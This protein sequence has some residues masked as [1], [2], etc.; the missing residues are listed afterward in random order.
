MTEKS[1]VTEEVTVGQLGLIESADRQTD[2]WRETE[3]TGDGEWSLTG[4][5]QR[6]CSC[7]ELKQDT[8]DRLEVSHKGLLHSK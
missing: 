2:G 1:V 3:W 5:A 8:A 6:S 4:A 7:T